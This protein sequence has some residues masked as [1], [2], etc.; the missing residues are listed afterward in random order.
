ML[1]LIIAV[2]VFVFFLGMVIN[3]P[4]KE[5][6]QKPTQ[7]PPDKDRPAVTK[8]IRAFG[9]DGW[10][11]EGD[12]SANIIRARK[13][14]GYE[15]RLLICFEEPASPALPRRIEKMIRLRDMETLSLQPQQVELSEEALS[16]FFAASLAE[17]INEL[18]EIA[19]KIAKEGGV[20]IEGSRYNNGETPNQKELRLL[21]KELEKMD[22]KVLAL[23]FSDGSLKLGIE[24]K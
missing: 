9:F 2:F 12:R 10:W 6:P 16:A 22:F 11:W 18:Q 8:F 17:N 19:D 23:R 20:W 24:S 4:E 3:R 5:E 1:K 21:G 15:E 14:N 13:A 7:L